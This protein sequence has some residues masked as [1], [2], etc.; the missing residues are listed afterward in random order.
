MFLFPG[1]IVAASPAARG[2]RTLF[3]PLLHFLFT[4]LR[5]RSDPMEAI[6]ALKKE[7]ASEWI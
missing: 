1:A 5:F 2:R 6:E 7:W 4:S 3:L